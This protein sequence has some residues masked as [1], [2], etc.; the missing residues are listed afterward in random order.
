M[1]SKSHFFYIVIPNNYK[2]KSTFEI[3]NF[4]KGYPWFSVN[5]RG[6]SKIFICIPVWVNKSYYQ[7][8]NYRKYSL[9]NITKIVIAELLLYNYNFSLD[10]KVRSWAIYKLLPKK[11]ENDKKKY[12]KKTHS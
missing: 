4:V 6:E 7:N 11:F 12:L 9:K 5:L 1:F 2:S 10:K 3:W 8:I